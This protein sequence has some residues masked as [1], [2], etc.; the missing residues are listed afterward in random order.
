MPDWSCPEDRFPITLTADMP[1]RPS[2]AYALEIRRGRRLVVVDSLPQILFADANERQCQKNHSGQTL[3]RLRE[4]H[5]L[6]ARE[7]L[8][9]LSCSDFEAFEGVSEEAA[10]RSLYN[11]VVT[12]NR[13]VL[14]GRRALSTGATKGE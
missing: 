12:F 5:G 14:V 1:I 3:E 8:A 9:I 10:F 6:S 4:R 7:A 13:G 11:T 2:L